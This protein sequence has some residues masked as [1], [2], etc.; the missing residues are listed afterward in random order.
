MWFTLRVLLLTIAVGI[1]FSQWT[2]LHWAW[3]GLLAVAAFG[4]AGWLLRLFS[5]K[6]IARF[7]QKPEADE[8]EDGSIVPEPSHQE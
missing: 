8:G 7:R 1:P 3:R 6:L 5:P 4:A 2:S